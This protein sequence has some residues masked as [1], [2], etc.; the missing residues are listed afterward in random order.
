MKLIGAEKQRQV[1]KRGTKKME[2]KKGDKGWLKRKK[3]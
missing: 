1:K 3:K 2:H